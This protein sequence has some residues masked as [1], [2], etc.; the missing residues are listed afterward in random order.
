LF[1]LA[2]WLNHQEGGTE[3]PWINESG[4]DAGIAA[5]PAPDKLTATL[6]KLD[7]DKKKRETLF[8]KTAADMQRKK[9]QAEQ[10]FKKTVDTINKD[11]GKVE[12]PFRDMDLD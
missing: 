3:I 11:G 2:R 7:A 4:S 5:G 10:L 6:N 12:K 9:T 1:V 8:E